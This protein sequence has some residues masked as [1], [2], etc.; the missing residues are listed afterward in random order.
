MVRRAVY[1]EPEVQ[2]P[3]LNPLLVDPEAPL[4]RRSW[5]RSAAAAWLAHAGRLLWRIVTYS[6]LRKGPIQIRIEDGAFWARVCRGILYRLTFVPLLLALSACAL[7]WSATHP[8]VPAINTDPSSQQIYYDPVNLLSD[9][10]TRLE[11]WLV[12]VFDAR[13]VLA[14]KELLLRSRSPA[15]VL[16]HDQARSLEQVLP[17]I[18]PLHDAGFVVLALGLRGR[19]G[20]QPAGVT[21]GLREAADARAAVELL[22]RRPYVDGTK[23]ALVGIGTGGNAAVIAA[24]ADPMIAAVAAINPLQSP[25]Q[26]LRERLG[27]KQ[28]WLAFLDPLCKWTFEMA[29][30][31]DLND[32][33]PAKYEQALGTRPA[34]INNIGP[35]TEL[36]A[37]HADE[38]LLFLDSR[39]SPKS[40]S[41]DAK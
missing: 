32:L 9:D 27:A 16:L 35:V 7:V 12:P 41:A 8:P 20:T 21:F 33:R 13:Q 3:I 30:Q 39:L 11:G 22:R 2:R 14:Q 5:R 1:R 37:R 36:G 34:L 17:L 25:R 40:V 19:G 6:P 10:G 26:A 23:I 31:A 15:V 29:Y 38:I 4:E 24:A 18:R 28:A